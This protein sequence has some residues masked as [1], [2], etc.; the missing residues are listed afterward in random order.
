VTITIGMN[1]ETALLFCAVWVLWSLANFLVNLLTALVLNA[2]SEWQQEH[3][4]PLMEVSR[5]ERTPSGGTVTE[6]KLPTR[7]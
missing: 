5:H 1:R 6:W 2:I 4:E 3:Q 7:L